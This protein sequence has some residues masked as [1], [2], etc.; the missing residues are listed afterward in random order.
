MTEPH[1]SHILPT[2]LPDSPKTLGG[3]L[4]R[5][6]SLDRPHA[7]VRLL[8]RQERETWWTWTELVDRALRAA[9]RM[10]EAGVR[11]GERVAIVLPTGTA[12]LEAFF[13]C[14]LLGA[15][16]TPLYP[17]VRLGRLD[18][19]HART[20]AM[21][22]AAGCTLLI[23]EPRIHRLMGQTLVRTR[24]EHGVLLDR[25]LVGGSPIEAVESDAE[26]L[27][28]VQFSSGTTVNPKPV[29]LSHRAVL[30]QVHAIMDQIRQATPPEVS[31]ETR[32]GVSWL[33][34]Y[35]DMGLIGFV[36]APIC[37]GIPIVF[38]PTLRFIKRPS[39]WL[40]TVH[41]H[42]G[43]ASFAPNFAYALAT[44]RVSETDLE[45]WDLS[46]LKVLGC[47]AEPIQA[48][49][50]RAF[51][52]KFH[53]AC[54]LPANSIMPAYG[55]AEATLAITLKPSTELMKTVV[56]DAEH[57]SE[58]GE[59]V[60]PDEGRVAV[61]H[62]ACGV[63]FE[64]HEVCIMDADGNALG[65]MREGE[66]CHRGPSVTPGYFENPEATAG[67]YKNGWLHTGDLGFL[68]G[69][70]VYVTGR[71][72]DLIIVNGRNVHPQ[73]VEWAAAEV[74]GIRKGN[75]VAFS[76]PGEAGEELV[77][78]C[79]TKSDPE[80]HAE[81]ADLVR[82]AVTRELSLSTA[83][84]LFLKPGGLPKTSSGKLQ[85]RKTRSEYLTGAIG[86][87]GPRTMGASGSKLTLAKHIA[88][89]VWTRAKSAIR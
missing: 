32:A 72:K 38:I 44:R 88:K 87:T 39:V 60:D 82:R 28:M 3:Y 76:I 57:F 1:P 78:V 37:H 42:R 11:P 59:V 12:F 52:E 2:S 71:I 5:A 21:L 55:M 23:T 68:K 26:D 53:A 41:R 65:D 9:G 61:E 50:M 40:D 16:P 85:R 15:V 73:A 89:S 7:G 81:L 13:G 74:E 19:F 51:T 54:G 35:H 70:E 48:A 30:A 77:I 29:A 58:T 24:P 84:I 6:A 10:Q 79:E 33:P 64:G 80:Q 46:C 63:P 36:I 8:D 86:G 34:L 47:G 69:G 27:C 18:E 83:D 67:S 75:V 62:V 22:S 31:M 66:I 45:K 14:T 43:T 17:P 4:L 20:A 56:L 49:T 25:D